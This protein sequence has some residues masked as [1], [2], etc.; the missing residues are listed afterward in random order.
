MASYDPS[1]TRTRLLEAAADEMWERGFQAAGMAAILDKAGVT[2]GALYHHF[3][4]KE[5]LGLAVIDELLATRIKEMWVAPL[6]AHS[7]PVM[8][9]RKSIAHAGECLDET[10][11]H[12][13]CLLNN[14]SQ[15]M[16]PVSPSFREHIQQLF[17]LWRS[18]LSEALAR[19]QEEGFVSLEIDPVAAAWVIVSMIEGGIG[20]LK[21]SVGTAAVRPDA[22]THGLDVYLSHLEITPTP[23]A[24]THE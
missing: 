5:A 23:K 10:M 22:L 8:G 18:G 13:G 6:A 9:I 21:A 2:K 3:G 1:E 17:D 16:C 11:L 19:G 14:L 4:S 12:R 24:L 15:E 7:N 20:M